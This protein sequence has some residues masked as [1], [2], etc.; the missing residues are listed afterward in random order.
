[1]SRGKYEIQLTAGIRIDGAGTLYTRRR[2]VKRG[3]NRVLV[4]LPA[5]VRYALSVW[6]SRRAT[7][8]G[9]TISQ[10]LCEVMW[11]GFQARLG[12]DAEDVIELAYMAYKNRCREN[13]EPNIFEAVEGS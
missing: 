6:G 5:A 8:R 9:R 4:S 10:E 11:D 1:M 2:A 13:G 7:M 12:K 3:G